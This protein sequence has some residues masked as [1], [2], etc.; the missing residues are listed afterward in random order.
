MLGGTRVG[1]E[2]GKYPRVTEHFSDAQCLCSIA[3]FVCRYIIIIAKLV[4][5]NAQAEQAEA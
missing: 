1:G 2:F 5:I 3:T 4:R